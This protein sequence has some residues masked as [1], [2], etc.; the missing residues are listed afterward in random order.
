M[1][2]KLEKKTS[3]ISI[4]K[5]I[6]FIGV[7]IV[8]IGIGV[9]LFI[10][11]NAGIYMLGT[12]E[13]KDG[14]YLNAIEYYS[15]I[16]EYRNTKDK[17]KEC[18]YQ[19]AVKDIEGGEYERSIENLLKIGEYKDSTSLILNV[20]LELIENY[21]DSN[22]LDEAK[23]L[24]ASIEVNSNERAKE[25]Y[26]LTEEKLAKI[27][28]EKGLFKEAME[29]LNNANVKNDLLE[30]CQRL[31]S[32]Q[33]TYRKTI[34]NIA[35]INGWNITFGVDPMYDTTNYFDQYTYKYKIENN[36]IILE[37]E[38]ALRAIG[39]GITQKYKFNEKNKII[40]SNTGSYYYESN[41]MDFPERRKEPKIGMTKSQVENSTWGKPNKINKTTTKY[42]IHEQWVYSNYKYL[43]FD[44]GI[45]TSIQD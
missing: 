19:I 17:W 11:S 30:K 31:L 25:L 2:N 24:I 10:N 29:H 1:K 38:I 8:L 13:M 14:N 23:E 27:K 18:Y 12:K 33:G 26:V 16:L 5:V 20:K 15:K 32:I 45:L 36:Q 37:G 3:G 34:I 7:I 21:I 40:S 28:Y 35:V 43:Y 42:G 4:V 9:T 41:K 44:D 22:E 6:A 39:N